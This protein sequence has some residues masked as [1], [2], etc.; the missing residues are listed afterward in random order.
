MRDKRRAYEEVITALEAHIDEENL[1]PGDRLPSAEDLA[2]ELGVSTRSV[3][4]AY[5]S[6]RAIGV[7]EF[8][9]GKGVYLLENSLDHYLESLAASL[10]FTFSQ[11][12]ELLL[13]LTYTRRL[14]ETGIVEEIATSP[15]AGL[16]QK[17]KQVLVDMAMALEE[18][19][20]TRYNELDGAFHE[21]I[22]LAS[23]NR[24]IGSLYMHLSRLLRESIEV[25]QYYG[26]RTEQ[27]LADHQAMVDH[28][29]NEQPQEAREVMMT[30]LDRTWS[31]I[32]GLED[33]KERKTSFSV[34]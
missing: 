9:Q 34:R 19:D 11:G 16:V 28:I 21:A 4:E 3:R 23:S 13:E 32:Q 7:V 33:V 18:G 14:I 1:R 27:S 25:T 5:A 24:I 8:K 30:H 20:L 17:L 22:V 10:H 31:T 26:G 29:E 6:L 2:R 12:K 15:P